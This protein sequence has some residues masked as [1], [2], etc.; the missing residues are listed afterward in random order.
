MTLIPTCTDQ[1]FLTSRLPTSI[2]IYPPLVPLTLIIISLF[3]VSKH[4]IYNP[5]LL[6]SVDADVGE[7]L[8]AWCCYRHW[9]YKKEKGEFLPPRILPYFGGWNPPPTPAIHPHSH[10]IP[11]TVLQTHSFISS[12][13]FTPLPEN[14][15]LILQHPT[16]L[17]PRA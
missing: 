12:C 13:L 8:Y 2:L 16:H 5:L 6:S 9:G 14:V 3:G 17:S 7:M 11:A 10:H 1:S 4:T 15:L